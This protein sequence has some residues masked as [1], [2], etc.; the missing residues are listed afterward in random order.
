MKVQNESERGEASESESES[1]RS[2]KVSVAENLNAGMRIYV[3]ADGD[4]R[5]PKLVEIQTCV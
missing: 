1:G 3:A 5:T 4:V 2:A